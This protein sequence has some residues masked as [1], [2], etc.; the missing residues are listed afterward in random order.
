MVVAYG[1]RLLAL[2]PPSAGELYPQRYKGISVCFNILRWALTG[3]Y[4]NFGVF[5]LYGTGGG[6]VLLLFWC[7][8][9]LGWGG[10]ARRRCAG[11]LVG[12]V[13]QDADGH[14]D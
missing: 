1:T 12:H 7:G 14:A 8:F 2:P 13:L 6:V 11:Q 10:N 4:V 5:K 3:D 9:I